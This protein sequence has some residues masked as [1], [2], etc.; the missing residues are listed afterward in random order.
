MN[1][2]GLTLLELIAVIAVIFILALLFVPSTCRPPRETRCAN[3]LRQLHTVGLVYA[4]MHGGQWLETRGEDLWL[5]FTRTT[6]PLIEAEHAAV[7]H[8]KV[9]DEVL[10]ED[11]TSYRGP[12]VSYSRVGAVDPLG[13]DKPGNHGENYGGNVL[14]KDG[15]VEEF[16]LRDSLWKK[17]DDL[18]RP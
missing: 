6:P 4:S 1:R 5:S 3:N 18:L 11:E 17:C 16:D 7:L 2:Q 13:A 10:G 8:C 9:M 15:R 12:L 14:F